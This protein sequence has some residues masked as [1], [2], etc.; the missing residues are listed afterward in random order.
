MSLHSA[1][2]QPAVVGELLQEGERTHNIL[3]QVKRLVPAE[4]GK[5]R[6]ART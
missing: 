4:F 2:R 3:R 6:R 5:E 1:A